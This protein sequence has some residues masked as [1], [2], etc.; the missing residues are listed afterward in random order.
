[1]ETASR[2]TALTSPLTALWCSG[3]R[4]GAHIASYLR[5]ILSMLCEILSV[6]TVALAM[7]HN[8]HVMD[9]M[10][11]MTLDI[12]QTASSCVHTHKLLLRVPRRRCQ[13]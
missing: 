11:H 5:E 6:L 12:S 7:L 3:F 1:M 8:A 10:L 13:Q 9:R 4:K 2:V